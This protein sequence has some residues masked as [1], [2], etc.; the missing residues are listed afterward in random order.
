M[1]SDNAYY[2]AAGA[3]AGQKYGSGLVEHPYTFHLNMVARA[4]LDHGF[5][6]EQLL[7]AAYL[8]DTIE[9]TK[10]TVLDIHRHFGRRVAE[11]VLA[12]TDKP[13]VNRAARHLATYPGIRAAGPRAVALK[14]ADRIANVQYSLD[15]D[16]EGK[17][18]MY[19]KEQPEFARMLRIG[20]EHAEM[21][22]TL[23]RL[24]GTETIDLNEKVLLVQD[25]P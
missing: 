2:F 19:R 11:L 4:L 16:D 22:N 8:H 10:V 17:M 6:Q 23:N 20:D 7:A 5:D 21:W 15:T 25:K 14:L 3:H 18:G 12:V 13:G 1:I 24:L 9:D